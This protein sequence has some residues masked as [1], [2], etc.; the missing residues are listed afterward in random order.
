MKDGFLKVAASSV[1]V[2]VADV[3][4]NRTAIEQRI[5]RADSERV[6]LL[7]LPE[8]A[9]SGYTCGDLFF[10]ETLLAAAK[11][12]LLTLADYTR[13][14]YPIVIVGLP[15]VHGGEL[16]NAAAVLFNGEVLGI[17]PKTYLPNHSD[18]EEA[19][20]FASG[21]HVASGA[22]V[23]LGARDVPFG[24]DLLFAHRELRDYIFGVEICED[25]WAPVPPSA[26][27]ACAGALLIANPT[28]SG[29]SVGKAAHRRMLVESAS[30]RLLCAYVLACAGPEESTQDGVFARHHLI[31]QKGTILAENAP[32]ADDSDLTVTEVDL[33]KLALERR[34]NASF[35]SRRSGEFR[36]IFFDQTV[37]QTRL[38]R[39]I[40][41]TPFVP[42]GAD[43][44]AKRAELILNIQSHGLAKRI[45]HTHARSIVLGISG[46]LDSTLALLVSVRAMAIA[47]RDRKDIIAVTMPCFG[48]TKRTKSNA[49][50]LCELL[51]V[52]LREINIEAS[53]KQ[54]FADIG[55]SEDVHDV[56]YENSQARERTQ[57]LMDLANKEGGFV[58]GT[59]DLS[60]LA[61]GWATYNGDHMSMYGVNGSVPKTLIR[62]I[63][64]YEAERAEGEL[65]AVL[66]DI[67]D[68][69]VSPELLPANEN[70][71]IAQK[72]E[73]LV[74]PYELHDFYLY[75]MMRTGAGPAK[76]LRLARH[77]FRG[78]YTDETILHWMRVFFRRFFNQQFK[79]SCLPDGPKVGS[80]ALSPRGDWRMPSDASSALWLSE[81][82]ALEREVKGEK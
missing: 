48:T 4:A 30:A 54:H 7:V 24:T 70:G 17:V 12:A 39:P 73:D 38:V 31:A 16:Y 15:I 34:K 69:P 77:A 64:R 80:V 71:E 61:L 66:L 78:E 10:S 76:M 28:A 47:G 51:G 82:D 22:V 36:E 68:T 52:T 21:A 20:R 6:N 3:L 62:P 35:A 37:R 33:Q 26:A 50:R 23:H 18:M 1:T 43:A 81:I 74:G 29:E 56:T 75:H 60:E 32:F 14:K 44:I 11:E 67:V 8:L 9:L 63:V 57:V 45:T 19:R 72:T 41:K 27:L 59:G 65:S 25:L 13:G 42:E 79:R 55:Q 5:D 40:A 53:V 46:G 49:V 2:S 58:V